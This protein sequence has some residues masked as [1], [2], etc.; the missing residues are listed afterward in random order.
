[1]ALQSISGYLTRV[2]HTGRVTVAPKWD[3]T[4]FPPLV[5]LLGGPKYNLWS[6][7]VLNQ[8]EG[9]EID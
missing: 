9:F 8:Y 3:A 2:R 6:K 4:D 5:I 1:M 7:Q